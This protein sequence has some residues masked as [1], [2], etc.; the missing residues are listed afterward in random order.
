MIGAVIISH[1]NLSEA[2]LEVLFQIAGEQEDI[3]AISNTGRDLKQMEEDLQNALGRLKDCDEVIF[4]SD[5]R[6]GSCSLICERLLKEN[7]NLALMTGY[8]LP[9]LIEFIFYRSK[10]LNELLS[11]LEKKGQGGITSFRYTSD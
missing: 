11:I 7:R 6:G 9:V 3:I 2:V 4:F 5:L 10:P 8:N 1:G